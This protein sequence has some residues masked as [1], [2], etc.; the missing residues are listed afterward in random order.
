ME[1]CV[2]R[3]RF[4]IISVA[5]ILAN[6]LADRITKIIAVRYLANR[7]PMSFLGNSVMILLAENEGAFLS[8]GSSWPAIIKYALLLVLPGLACCYGIYHC[9]ARETRLV[10]AIL[11]STIIGGGLGNLIDRLFNDFR[12]I[13]FLNFGIGSIRTGILNVADL[14]VT[15]GALLLLAYEFRH[16]KPA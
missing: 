8:M 15:F 7:P 2:N 9:L 10:R 16:G 4:I 1:Y 13:D 14:S 3:K 5:T 6:Y 12:V 11:I